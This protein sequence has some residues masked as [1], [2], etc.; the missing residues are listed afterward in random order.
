[1]AEQSISITTFN[2]KGYS[3]SLKELQELCSTHRIICIQEHWLSKQTLEKLNC[4]DG[5]FRSCG[6]SPVDS[7]SGLL[8]GRP[9]GGVGILW[10]TS[11]DTIVSPL[12]L[13]YDWM[14]GITVNTGLQKF[15]VL[16]VYLP[17]QCNENVDS[18]IEC[19]NSVVQA[20]LEQC[21]TT[22]NYIFGDFNCDVYN[23]SSF[24]VYLSRF[25]SDTD[26]VISDM[27]F[28]TEGYTFVS[29]TWGTTSWLDHCVSS[30]DAHKAITSADI[31]Y[32]YISSDHLP[33]SFTISL[34][35]LPEY[36]QNCEGNHLPRVIWDKVSQDMIEKYRTECRK[37]ISD[38]NL[39]YDGLI[40]TNTCCTN[41]KHKCDIDSLYNS[42]VSCIQSASNKTL[43]S[44]H[45]SKCKP[46]PGWT[47]YVQDS[48]AAAREAFLVWRNAGKPRQGQLFDIMKRTKSLFK[49]ALRQCK[50]SEAK[51]RADTLAKNMG[52]KNY[53]A[54]WKNIKM[55]DNSKLASPT[56][57]GEATGDHGITNMWADHYKSIFSCLEYDTE[58]VQSIHDQLMDSTKYQDLFVEPLEICDAIRNLS[59]GKSPG[60]DR[61]SPEHIKYSSDYLLKPLSV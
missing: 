15:N 55:M 60:L 14:C 40:C 3:S 12:K 39:L 7:G 16:S 37:N 13:D 21:D 9:Y 22:C 59:G 56:V 41:P 31:N 52:Q 27:E 36:K 10:H 23:K 35:N 61:I 54:F 47:D 46:V 57:I 5:N 24:S 2:C 34:A 4:I 6:V 30:H 26:Y 49:Y 8:T 28:I 51:I 18:Y 48:H 43:I 29:D 53:C 44:S 45:S 32:D 50:R 20:F 25:I 11:L 19:L 17:Y 33:L 38:L 58:S 1:M 42:L